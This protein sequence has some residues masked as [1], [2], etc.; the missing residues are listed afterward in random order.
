MSSTVNVTAL[1]FVRH[2][3]EDFKPGDTIPGIKKDDLERLEGLGAVKVEEVVKEPPPPPPVDPPPPPK[4]PG[5]EG[6]DQDPPDGE[7][8]QE[9]P[10]NPGDPPKDSDLEKDD[11]K[12]KK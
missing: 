4:E 12:G 6:N 11:K 5:G 1:S 7:N 2:N 8:D 10:K 3:N 9:P